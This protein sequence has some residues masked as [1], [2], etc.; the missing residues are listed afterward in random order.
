MLTNFKNITK[1]SK[2]TVGN[3]ETKNFIFD[4]ITL[5][6]IFTNKYGIINISDRIKS[7]FYC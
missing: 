6:I 3:K 2:P 5:Y 7:L 1:I 4:N